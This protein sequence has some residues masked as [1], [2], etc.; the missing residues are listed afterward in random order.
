RATPP[1]RKDRRRATPAAGPPGFL[2]IA[3]R[4]YATI[5]VDGRRLGVTPIYRVE[6][7]S[8]KRRVRADC[9]CGK[10][11]SFVVD[12]EPGVAAPARTLTW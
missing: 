2:T 11:R 12:I 6:V 5:F 7:A 9:S 4:P 3:S 8:G 1:R 10:T